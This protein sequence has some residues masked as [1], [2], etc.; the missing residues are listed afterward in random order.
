MN[1]GFLAGVLGLML[2]L[3]AAAWAVPISSLLGDKDCFGTGGACIEDGSTWAV[4]SWSQVVAEPSDPAFT[5][6]FMSTSAST[7]WSHSFA[8][9]SY[10]SASLSVRTLGIADIYGPYTVYVDGTAVGSM[11]LD[12]YGHLLAETFEFSVPESV[13]ADGLAE[14]SF[15][16]VAGDAWA[17]DYSELTLRS[18]GTTVPE[19]GM[20]ALLAVGLVGVA[21]FRPR[22]GTASA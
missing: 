2:A 15:T 6:R 14:V 18:N 20:L 7:S 11:P 10:G 4:G 1:K 9:G 5:D 17:I 13:V 22:A 3:P 21:V 19:P 12:G 16:S 8:A